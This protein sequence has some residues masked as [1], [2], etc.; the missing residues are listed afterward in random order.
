MRI[1]DRESFEFRKQSAPLDSKRY[2]CLV[3]LR[4]TQR[5]LHKLNN[6][7]SRL[8]RLNVAVIAL[9]FGPLINPIASSESVMR[10]MQ[11]NR[12]IDA[13]TSFVIWSQ[14]RVRAELKHITKRRNWNN[15]DCLSNGKRSCK[16][17]RWKLLSFG[18]KEL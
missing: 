3:F 5:W 12:Y 18:D 16:S 11:E 13:K 17:P 4:Q 6:T 15:N 2:V 10:A 7:S 1:A 9:D 14:A 8:Q